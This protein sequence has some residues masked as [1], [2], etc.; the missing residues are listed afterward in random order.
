M[1]QYRC[2]AD[3]LT[4]E[5]AVAS[6]S[7]EKTYGAAS[8]ATHPELVAFH[9]YWN[10]KRG[11]RPWPAREDLTPRDLMRSLK[12][13]HLYDVIDNGEEFHIRVTGSAIF[14][15]YYADPTGKL[16]SDHPD[17][18]LRV[19]FRNVLK[20][21][22][23]TGQPVYDHASPRTDHFLTKREAFSL[24]LPLG[25]EKIEQVIAQSMIIRLQY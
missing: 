23:E 2:M 8:D 1:A 18:G 7:I 17:P 20:R 24:W 19:A 6:A 12:R 4:R 21:V 13:I 25:R 15:G 14:L 22:L 9:E 3:T 16:V 10:V 5:A 11:H